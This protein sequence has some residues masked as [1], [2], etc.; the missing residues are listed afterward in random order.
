MRE[1]LEGIQQ[2]NISSLVRDH[3][4][5]IQATNDIFTISKRKGKCFRG[6]TLTRPSMI[7]ISN[8]KPSAPSKRIIFQFKEKNCVLFWHQTWHGQQTFFGPQVGPLQSSSFHWC[9]LVNPAKTAS[10]KM[11]NRESIFIMASI[12][13][14]L[15]KA[16]CVF[17]T[18][19]LFLADAANI[20][21]N[22]QIR[23]WF[24]RN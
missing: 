7:I 4:F 20:K 6:Q 16:I 19:Y 15:F 2:N 17:V 11:I 12:W 23:G 1:L 18:C 10:N 21:H 5:A 3:W 24:H 22:E 8:E 14:D 9:P 13:C